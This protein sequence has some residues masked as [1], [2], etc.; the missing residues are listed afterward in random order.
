LSWQSGDGTRHNLILGFGLVSTKHHP[1]NSANV[2][3]AQTLG[4]AI[5]TGAPQGGLVL[6]YQSIQQTQ[7]APNWQGIMQVNATPGEPLK[8]EGH[9]PAPSPGSEE[10]IPIT[11]EVKP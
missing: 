6:G 5:R 7:I 9:G 10:N 8:V 1:D 11:A 2:M 4:L 3:R